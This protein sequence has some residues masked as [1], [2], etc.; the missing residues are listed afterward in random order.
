MAEAI[1]VAAVSQQNDC[2][3]IG[4]MPY[5]GCKRAA[6]RVMNCMPVLTLLIRVADTLSGVVPGFATYLSFSVIS[7]T[8]LYVPM[9]NPTS[10]SAHK[11]TN[12]VGR[13]STYQSDTATVFTRVLSASGSRYEPKTVFMLNVLAIHP[14][15]RSDAEATKHPQ[16][17]HS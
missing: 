17:A 16:R 6:E 13:S 9:H 4:S 7:A 1:V 3:I 11:A 2:N 10:L 12:G 8:Y 15:I 14:S 5:I